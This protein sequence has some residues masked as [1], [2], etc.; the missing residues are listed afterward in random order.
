MTKQER[1]KYLLAK[2]REYRK[3]GKDA[4]WLASYA[5]AFNHP[6]FK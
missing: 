6:N 4:A 2:Q 5:R 3:Q 1:I